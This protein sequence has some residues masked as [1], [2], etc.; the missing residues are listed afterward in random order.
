VSTCLVHSFSPHV[1]RQAARRFLDP[2]RDNVYY[3][4]SPAITWF[5]DELVLVS[6]VWLDRERSVTDCVIDASMSSSSSSTHFVIHIPVPRTTCDTRRLSVCWSVSRIT[7]KLIGRFFLNF[8]GRLDL[9]QFRG[10]SILV[11]IRISVWIQDRIEGF[12]A[13]DTETSAQ[14]RVATFRIHR[15]N[16]HNVGG[17]LRPGVP[18]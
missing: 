15:K 12:F 14:Y 11:V 10:V 16:R 8:Q 5:N 1:E 7:Q 9:A 3:A 17:N 2:A 6:R 4:N 18:F 13:M